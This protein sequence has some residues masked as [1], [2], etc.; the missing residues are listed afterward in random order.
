MLFQFVSFQYYVTRFIFSGVFF[1][2]LVFFFFFFLFSP[3][4]LPKLLSM[5]Y[6]NAALLSTHEVPAF[7]GG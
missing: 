7:I 1:C 4:P 3:S 6:G 5:C 2:F